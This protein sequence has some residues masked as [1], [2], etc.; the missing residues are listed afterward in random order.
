MTLR[1][2][3][4]TQPF[5][6][7]VAAFFFGNLCSQT[8]HV[9]QVAY[10]VDHGLAA[11]VAASVVSVVG[12]ASIAGKIGG[13][14]LS[15]RMERELVYVSGVAVMAASAGVLLALGAAPSPMGAYGFAVLLGVGYS[16]TA[17]LTP[18][19]VSDRF[20]GR[21]FGAIVGIG[22]LGAAVGSALGPWLAGWLYDRT[23]SYTTAFVIAGACG[24]I[25]GAAAWRARTL[26][27]ADHA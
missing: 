8:L 7:L 13:G 3:A 19:M 5:W 20:S 27:K 16:A 10:L 15:D 12:L 21:H 25:A 26:R 24:V 9:H 14:W 11:L 2:A 23:A 1:E 6:L 18:A 17:T 4:R 22:L